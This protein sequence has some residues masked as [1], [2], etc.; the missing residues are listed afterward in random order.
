M[1]A[2]L[3][4]EFDRRRGYAEPTNCGGRMVVVAQLS[5]IWELECDQCGFSAGMPMREA[6]PELYKSQLVE[7]RRN[8]S[9]IP[10]ALQG[11]SL[12]DDNF[13]ASAAV[14]EW[15]TG[16]PA[17]QGLTL[18]G[19]VGVGKTHRA[20]SAAWARLRIEPLRWFSVP[21]LFA[22]LGRAFTDDGRRDAL[23]VLVGEDVLVLDDIDK[24]RPSEY[25][26]EQLFTAIDSRVTAGAG[27]L[28]TT[29][30]AL[31][32]LADRFPE[33][34]GYAIASRLAG[35]S[36]TFLIKGKDR[37]LRGVAA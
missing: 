22:Q 36:E 34:F 8:R 21:V 29:N 24:T 31:S 28:V 12:P 15:A 23:D 16:T 37:R 26:A 4:A 11:L 30:L 25:A 7:R 3:H 27:L 20:A 5:G 6:D 17:R 10:Q 1:S 9:G 33:P 13:P 35:Y 2:E 19:G 18:T 32:A 14:R